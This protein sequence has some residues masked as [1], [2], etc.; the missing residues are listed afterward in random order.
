MLFLPPR[1]RLKR[2]K[3]DVSV[4]VVTQLRMIGVDD[5]SGKYVETDLGGGDR[6]EFWDRVS[7]PHFPGVSEEVTINIKVGNRAN[8]QTRNL[9]NTSLKI[10]A[11]KAW[12]PQKCL[13]FLTESDRGT[14]P[15]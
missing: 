13:Y 1:L 12:S 11:I 4:A 10:I 5:H 2:L 15:P 8:I 9:P 6:Y 14:V 3:Y 7:N